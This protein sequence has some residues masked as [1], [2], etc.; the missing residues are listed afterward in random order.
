MASVPAYKCD[1]GQQ[2]QQNEDAIWVDKQAGLFIIADGMGGQEAGDI[3]SRLTVETA[4]PLIVQQ[5]NAKN[6]TDW[7]ADEIRVIVT[8]AIETANQTVFKAAQQAE[9]KRKMGATIVV[10]LVQPSATYISHAGDSRAYLVQGSSLTQLTE[11]DSW[12]TFGDDQPQKER[13]RNKAI[14]HI[15]TKSIGQES[16]VEPSFKV[17][18]PKLGSYL[19]LC[20]DGLWDMINDEQ[21]LQ[22]INASKGNPQQAVTALVNAANSAGGKDNISVVLIKFV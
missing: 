13:G 8:N 20:S 10:A 7:S 12:R 21:I 3:A 19:L 14:D 11:D 4:G 5:L 9:Q 6:S 2:R 22:T 17:L 15:L 16:K 1:R 18:N